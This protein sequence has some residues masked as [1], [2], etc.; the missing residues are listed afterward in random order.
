M[1]K[2]Q[3]YSIATKED[4]DT[5]ASYLHQLKSDLNG[6]PDSYAIKLS[7]GDKTGVMYEG[8]ITPDTSKSG[9]EQLTKDTNALMYIRWL[10]ENNEGNGLQEALWKMNFRGHQL[11][12]PYTSQFF[13]KTYQKNWNL[14]GEYFKKHYGY[15]MLAEQDF[16]KEHPD[17]F[18]TNFSYDGIEEVIA[19][20]VENIQ[21][22]TKNSLTKI[23]AIL[24]AAKAGKVY[25]TVEKLNGKA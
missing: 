24:K 14:L 11:E 17:K 25:V 5:F 2:P 7:V 6:S 19:I 3:E 4:R 10:R 21:G 22:R 12:P 23:D 13:S 20:S 1:A 16:Q 15:F 18:K 8:V 9:L